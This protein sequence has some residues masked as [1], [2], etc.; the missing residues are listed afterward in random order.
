MEVDIALRVRDFDP[1]FP[2]EPSDPKADFTPD[3]AGVG[4]PD[5]DPVV[6][7]ESQGVIADASKITLALGSLATSG[8]ALSALCRV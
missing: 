4:T 2:A 8:W 1:R 5:I 7:M 3:F 6:E